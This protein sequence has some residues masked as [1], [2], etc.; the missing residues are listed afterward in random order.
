MFLRGALARAGAARDVRAYPDLGLLSLSRGLNCMPLRRAD[1]DVGGPRRLA[2]A[3]EH[4]RAVGR[5]N[6]LRLQEVD[7]VIRPWV[8]RRAC[9]ERVGMLDEAFRPTEWDEA[10]LAFRIRASGMEGRDLRLRAARRVLPSGQ[11]DDRRTPSANKQAT[12]LKNGRLFH[13]RW[14]A[15]ITARHGACGAR[16][17]AADARGM[18]G[19]GGRCEPPAH[20]ARTRLPHHEPHVRATIAALF[21]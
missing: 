17:D 2:A 6:W 11:H 3:A 5:R 7:A 14:D 13:S 1:R 12:V 10:D 20:G 8:V 19:D 4:D 16:G 15:V 9:I 21:A 18:A